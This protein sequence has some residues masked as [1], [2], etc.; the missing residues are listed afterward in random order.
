MASSIHSR[1]ASDDSNAASMSYILEHVM[2]YPGSYDVPLR[3][4]H[5]INRNAQLLSKDKSRSSGNSSPVTAQ[6]AW[7]SNEAATMTFTSQLMK[8]LKAL[9]TRPSSLPP[10]FVISFVNRVFHPE[11]QCVDFAQALTALDYL[12]SLEMRRREETIAAFERLHIRKESFDTDMHVMAE[13]FPGIAL[14][15]RNVDGKNKKAEKYY[16]QV[17]LGVRRWVL[18]NVLSE[19]PFNKLDCLSY[20]NTLLPPMHDQTKLPSLHLSR[21]AIKE[22]REVF[23]K[24]ISEVQKHGP[25]VL[26]PYIHMHKGAEDEN[27]WPTM[28]R[29]IEKYLRVT[30]NMMQDCR[31]TAG[32]ESFATYPEE[33]PKEKKHDSGVSFGSERRPSIGPSV[34]ENMAQE[35]VSTNGSKGL[36]KIERITREFRR[37]RVK[38]RTEVEEMVHI[39]QPAAAEYIPPTGN[40]AGKRLKKARSLAS[41]KFAN[42]SS[43]SL[44]S[45]RKNSDAMPFDVEQMRK[46]RMMYEASAQKT[47]NG[48][49]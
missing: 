28:H 23:F 18:L 48:R 4:M 16:A 20:L 22:E 38:P 31:N 17:W 2:Q 42:G 5:E 39:S 14:W 45:S 1:N 15:V 46:H 34:H 33:Q 12:S 11:L 49:A 29:I 37:M 9:P 41:L 32:P 7:N 44:I 24:L 26:Q 30:D 13:K 27:G 10:A 21:Q 35:P 19:Q 8:Q 6:G 43:T 36:S 25:S 3:T 47:V 40:N